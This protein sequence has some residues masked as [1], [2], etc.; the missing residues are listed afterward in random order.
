ME[1]VDE[2]VDAPEDPLRRD[3]LGTLDGLCYST[4]SLRGSGNCLSA[5]LTGCLSAATK[6]QGP[7]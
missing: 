3:G 5:R 2:S 6:S 4:G 7:C 1:K